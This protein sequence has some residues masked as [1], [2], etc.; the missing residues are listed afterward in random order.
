MNRLIARTLGTV[1]IAAFAIG[2]LAA[3][4]TTT[5]PATPAAKPAAKPKATPAPL[6]DI[7]TATKEDLMKLTGITDKLADGIIKG[8]PFTAKSQLTS[9]K[10]LTTAVYNKISAKIIAKAVKK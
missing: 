9:K 3:Q 2:P 1:L 8:R 6:L 7:N 5:P 4:T 10:I